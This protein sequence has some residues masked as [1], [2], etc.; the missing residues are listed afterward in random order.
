MTKPPAGDADKWAG[1]LLTEALAG[2]YNYGLKEMTGEMTPKMREDLQRVRGQKPDSFKVT[3]SRARSFLKVSRTELVK[4]MKEG[5]GELV[6]KDRDYLESAGR[7][8]KALAGV[9]AGICQI[10]PDFSRG[11]AERWPG[12]IGYRVALNHFVAVSLRVHSIFPKIEY[13]RLV[14]LVVQV[15]LTPILAHNLTFLLRSDP[16]VF[17]VIAGDGRA[18]D[19][20]P[21]NKSLLACYAEDAQ[22]KS[23]GRVES[24]DYAHNATLLDVER[25]T[26]SRWQLLF[27][28]FVH[29]HPQKTEAKKQFGLI[30]DLVTEHVENPATSRLWSSLADLASG[31]LS[32]DEMLV[33]KVIQQD[34][35]L[36]KKTDQTPLVNCARA[37]FGLLRFA[38]KM[39]VETEL[40]RTDPEKALLDADRVIKA[41]EGYSHPGYTDEPQA[42]KL[43]GWAY[44]LSRRILLGRKVKGNPGYGLSDDLKNASVVLDFEWR[45]S[46]LLERL[47]VSLARTKVLEAN[48]PGRRYGLLALRYWAGVRSNPR[49]IID[50]KGKA[51]TS[52]I[53]EAIT[54]L[55]Q[56]DAREIPKGVVWMLMARNA[57]HQAHLCRN[58]PQKHLVQLDQALSHYART[59]DAIFDS[60]AR[61]EED[62]SVRN[63][64]GTMDGE[65]AAW[66]IPEMVAAI[67]M[68][69]KA[70][71]DKKA[72]LN[73]AR[74]RKALITAGEIQFG[75]YF[76]LESELE[77]ITTGLRIRC[78]L[79]G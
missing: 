32:A 65:I 25:A 33:A 71:V 70:T 16:A 60:K 57:L 68:K 8:E 3:L 41:H 28:A 66:C 19:G 48:A 52:Y 50:V 77:R 75:I 53:E 13:D 40:L 62:L 67:S 2:L 63:N 59:L 15:V 42:L 34:G 35:D 64:E 51:G 7:V 44:L 6:K 30:K 4:M 5:F 36:F 74:Y 27:D 46:Q 22:F 47:F 10:M 12:P 38:L 26:L 49:F 54:R 56:D 21:I 14:G 9:E 45:A 61:F 37:R 76:N 43:F 79:K 20:D 1:L 17:R 11:E 24:Q 23:K 18:R 78:D 58:Q 69:E 31:D 73:I 72:K 29:F 39:E 55:K